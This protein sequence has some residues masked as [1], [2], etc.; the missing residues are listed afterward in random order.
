MRVFECQM[1][2]HC[3]EGR[4]GIVL[5]AKDLERLAL[6]L[7][8]PVAEFCRSHAEPRGGKLVVR[9]GADGFCV[10]FLAGTGCAVHPARPDVCR[11]WP[12][13][14]GNLEDPV[15][16]ELAASDCPGIRLEAGFAEFRRQGL[17]Y[18]RENGLIADPDDAGAANALKIRG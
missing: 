1:C 8:L 7:G 13:F 12:F 14:R 9:S 16:L 17:D 6:H 5:A 11:A 10:F 2:G 4:G 3:C 15:S 18:L